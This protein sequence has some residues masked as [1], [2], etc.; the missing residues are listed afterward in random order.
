MHS[1]GVGVTRRG[2]TIQ[3]PN[4]YECV[5]NIAAKLE[6]VFIWVVFVRPKV[7]FC[8]IMAQHNNTF[9]KKWVT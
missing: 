9:S 1:R 8:G 4:Y 6:Q 2:R 3:R 7:C 5:V